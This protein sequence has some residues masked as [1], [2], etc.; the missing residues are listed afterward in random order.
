MKKCL[1]IFIWV[2]LS[3]LITAI[4]LQGHALAQKEKEDKTEDEAPSKAGQGL[5]WVPRLAFPPS[6]PSKEA[7][8]LPLFDRDISLE[9]LDLTFYLSWMRPLKACGF[10]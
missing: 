3:M 4:V 8:Y 9:Y 1:G 10:W 2:T 7:G 5:I 6:D